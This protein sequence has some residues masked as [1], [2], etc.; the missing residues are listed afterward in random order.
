MDEKAIA[1]RHRSAT[2]KTRIVNIVGY[3]AIGRTASPLAATIK[4][5]SI[6]RSIS[7]KQ[8]NNRLTDDAAEEQYDHY[9]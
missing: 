8:Q 6:C 9:S 7:N 2:S 4:T 5:R 1:Q 3:S